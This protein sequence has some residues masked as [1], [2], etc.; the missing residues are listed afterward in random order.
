MR[1]QHKW[2]GQPVFAAGYLLKCNEHYLLI[3]E[4]GKWSDLGGKCERCDKTPR[5][6]ARREAAE[7]SLDTFPDVSTLVHREFYNHKS[8]YLLYV[9]EV[10]T[11]H[12]V[13]EPL[14]W[15]RAPRRHSLHPRLRYHPRRLAFM[16]R[17]SAIP[18]WSY[19]DPPERKH[20][21]HRHR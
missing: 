3:K 8:K 12:E 21:A 2:R 16:K 14:A 6:T 10:C 7:E 13:Q 1:T 4:R 9:V 17:P 15:V 5:E 18:T 11:M 19:K 20:H